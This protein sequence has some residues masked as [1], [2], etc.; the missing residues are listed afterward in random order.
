MLWQNIKSDK[1]FF[2]LLGKS[3]KAATDQAG[4][5]LT[6]TAWQIRYQ[7]TFRSALAQSPDRTGGQCALLA[8]SCQLSG[9]SKHLDELELGC[10]SHSN[11]TRIN[12]STVIAAI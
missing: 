10:L 7:E 4:V 3:R 11:A 2:P 12:P 9:D 6:S 8:N 5:D 1:L